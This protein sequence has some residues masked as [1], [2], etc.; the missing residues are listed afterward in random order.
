MWL[1]TRTNFK[2]KLNK[3]FGCHFLL[4]MKLTHSWLTRFSLKTAFTSLEAPQLSPTWAPPFVFLLCIYILYSNRFEKLKRTCKCLKLLNS[5]IFNYYLFGG[6][7]LRHFPYLIPGHL[8]WF[9]TTCFLFSFWGHFNAEN[10]SPPQN[11]RG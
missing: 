9:L 10:P 7:R 5:L 4:P 3:V 11:V 2:K 1:R 8:D 6:H